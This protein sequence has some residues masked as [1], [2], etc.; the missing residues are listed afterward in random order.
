MFDKVVK[1]TVNQ[2]VQ[3]M[4]HEQEHFRDLLSRLLTGETTVQDWKLL[5]S[6]QPSN[7]SNWIQFHNA[8]RL[9]CFNEEVAN[10]NHDQ[11]TKLHH[12]IARIDAQHFSSSSKKPTM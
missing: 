12:P 1:L 9:F 6:S 10:F 5:L 2:R 11:L 3:G 4:S 8:T 7:I